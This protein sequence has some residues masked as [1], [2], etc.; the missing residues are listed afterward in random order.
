M[1]Y[2]DP[3]AD[4]QVTLDELLLGQRRAHIADEEVLAQEQRAGEI[5]LRMEELM[6]TKSASSYMRVKDLFK[7]LDEDGSGE[8]TM[9]ELRRGLLRLGDVAKGRGAAEAKRKHA[10][11]HKKSKETDLA[12]RARFVRSLFLLLNPDASLFMRG[13]ITLARLFFVLFFFIAGESR[14]LNLC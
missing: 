11:A 9:A 12:E 6:G 1:R 5:M 13:V 4:G 8:I 10:Q 14:R 7:K 2:M 3:D